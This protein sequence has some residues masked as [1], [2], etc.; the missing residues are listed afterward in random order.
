VSDIPGVG[1]PAFAQRYFLSPWHKKSPLG[2]DF[3]SGLN[4]SLVASG[5]T[6]STI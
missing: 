2:G 4:Y 5:R 3:G 6:K 1:K